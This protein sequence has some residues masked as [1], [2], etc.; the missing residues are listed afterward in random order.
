VAATTA[1]ATHHACQYQPGSHRNGDENAAHAAMGALTSAGVVDHAS[2]GS[3]LWC[4]RWRGGS[5]NDHGN[6]LI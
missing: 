2:V 1:S 3:S 6:V 5:L 4:G